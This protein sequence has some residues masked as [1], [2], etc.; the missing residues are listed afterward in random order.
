ML[1]IQSVLIL[2]GPKMRWHSY[3]YFITIWCIIWSR[4]YSDQY[5]SIQISLFQHL[6]TRSNSIKLV[7]QQQVQLREYLTIS[8]ITSDKRSIRRYFSGRQCEI[9]NWR[10]RVKTEW[11]TII[12]IPFAGLHAILSSLDPM[13][14]SGVECHCNITRYFDYT[15]DISCSFTRSCHVLYTS[16]Y[17][18]LRIWYI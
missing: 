17:L 11:Q 1:L 16:S 6:Q 9:Q 18:N 5:G 14:L 12:Q 2:R 7:H 4:K 13:D 15:L 8:K 3:L 10:G